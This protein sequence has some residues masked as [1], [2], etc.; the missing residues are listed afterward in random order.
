MLMLAS[1]SPRRKALL[2][3]YGFSFQA[4]SP[5]VDE[6]VVSPQ[7]PVS[8][9]QQLAFE[10]ANAVYKKHT[11]NIVIGAD[12]I[13]YKEDT[14]FGKPKDRL[15]AF[16]MLKELSGKTHQVYTGVCI[17]ATGHQDLFHTVSNVTFKTLTKED[18]ITYIDTFE[19]YDKA[20]AYGIQE[21]NNI[22]VKSFDG[23]FETIVGFPMFLIHSKLT[24][25]IKK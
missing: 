20:G 7:D 14:Y 18:I 15:D 9:V 19:P 10:K 4:I 16:N 5:N 25:L 23:A 2:E 8:Y 6:S 17:L 13:V 24:R 22:L 11:E 12:T 3:K 1:Q 21:E